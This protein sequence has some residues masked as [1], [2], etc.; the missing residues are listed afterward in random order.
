MSPG[1]GIEWALPRA[2]CRSARAGSAPGR[3]GL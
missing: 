1:L 3:P 2:E